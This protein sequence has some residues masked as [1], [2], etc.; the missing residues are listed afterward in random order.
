MSHRSNAP[1][2]NIVQAVINAKGSSWS[3]STHKVAR[4]DADRILESLV[5]SLG[6]EACIQ[7]LDDQG[8]DGAAYRYLLVP[9]HEEA[10]RRRAD[11]Q[12]G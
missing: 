3:E 4:T 7:A 1:R 5:A 12:Q 2:P 6:V 8:L 11:A 10:A 9:L